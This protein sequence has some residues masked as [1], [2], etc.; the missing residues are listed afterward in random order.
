[1]GGEAFEIVRPEHERDEEPIVDV[2]ELVGQRSGKSGDFGTQR[3]EFFDERAAMG[4]AAEGEG[5]EV[6]EIGFE[7]AVHRGSLKFKVQRFKV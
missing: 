6:A 5:V 3:V 4:A 2:P 1:M 7:V